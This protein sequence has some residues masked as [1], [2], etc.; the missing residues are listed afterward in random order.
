MAEG[1]ALNPPYGRDASCVSAPEPSAHGI[2]QSIPDSVCTARQLEFD[3]LRFA[4]RLRGLGIGSGDRVLLQ[5]ENSYRYVVALFSLMLLDASIVLADH[6][7][8][9]LD[10]ENIAACAA[11][12]WKL[13]G[14]SVAYVAE[15]DQSGLLYE[16]LDTGSKSQVFG[17]PAISFSIDR[18]RARRDAAILWTSGSTGSP[19]GVVKSGRSIIDNSQRTRTAMGYCEDDV[20]M[21]L[22][23]FSHQYGFSLLLTWWLQRCSLLVTSQYSLT[24]SAVRDLVMGGATVVDAVPST[25][26]SLLGLLQKRPNLAQEGLERVRMWCVGGSPLS[27]KLAADFSEKVGAPLLD[28]YG[29]T[30][31]GN[32]ALSSSQSPTWCGRPLQGIHVRVVDGNGRVLPPNRNGEIQVLSP[33]VMGGY[34]TEDGSL[35]VLGS[36]W[37]RTRD[38]GCLDSEGHLCVIGR[39]NAVDRMGYTLYPA[40]VERKLEAGG[41]P[42]K[43]VAL[44][45][46][47]RGVSLVLFVE[48][49]EERAP[50]YWRT[51]MRDLLSPHERPNVLHVLR[52]L[53]L[54]RNGK[55]DAARLKKL[56]MGGSDTPPA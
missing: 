44:D 39:K 26:R 32:V 15:G 23:P 22:L 46:E 16:D 14:N 1:V 43:I 31:L 36:G 13:L 3:A 37:Y 30:E 7:L 29:L 19:K 53:P 8:N 47:K 34:L 45:D 51:K 20:L 49:S 33:D 41:C 11:V 4:A 2:Q 50:Q 55:V 38:L 40:S 56:A 10:V 54:S 28:G 35:R 27:P 48:D 25:Y 6:R 21:P 42:G 12:R 52:R 9:Q 5:G 18:W 24:A 17:S